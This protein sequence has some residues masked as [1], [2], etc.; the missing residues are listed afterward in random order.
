MCVC[1]CVCYPA[2]LSLFHFV[3]CVNWSV[4]LHMYIFRPGLHQH[5]NVGPVTANDV[6]VTPQIWWQSD[7]MNGFH[8]WGLDGVT[9]ALYFP[10]PP[11]K[12]GHGELLISLSGVM[13]WRF[14][15]DGANVD[16]LSVNRDLE[17]PNLSDGVQFSDWEKKNLNKVKLLFPLNSQIY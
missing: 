14:G 4:L 16:G 15:G 9:P 8:L 13:V 10:H 3:F 2:S 17:P 11:K 7:E 6:T 1:V 12:I 5:V